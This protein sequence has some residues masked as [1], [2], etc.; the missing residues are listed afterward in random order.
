MPF[1]HSIAGP[2]RLP[3]HILPVHLPLSVS[4][5]RSYASR[6]L[7]RPDFR[8][9]ADGKSRTKMGSN[10]ASL[11]Q[12]RDAEYGFQHWLLDYGP[13]FAEPATGEKARWLGDTVVSWMISSQIWSSRFLFW[14]DRLD[15]TALPWKPIFQTTSTTFQ[16]PT[17][18]AIRKVDEDGEDGRTNRSRR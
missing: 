18:K 2:S 7:R 3:A 5:V 1:L 11:L 6:P 16:R 17:R 9:D 10:S 15:V 4:F 8:E 13:E 14:T 12:E